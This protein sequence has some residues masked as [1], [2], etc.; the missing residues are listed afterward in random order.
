MIDTQLMMNIFII[1]QIIL[2]KAEM[3][4]EGDEGQVGKL[5]ESEGQ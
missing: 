1:G 3:R 2:E 4:R 5:G